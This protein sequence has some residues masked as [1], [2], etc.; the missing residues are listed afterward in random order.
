MSRDAEPARRR[1]LW[2]EL[3]GL[4]IGL[5]LLFAFKSDELPELPVLGAVTLL[6][7][8]YLWRDVGFDPQRFWSWRPHRAALRRVLLRFVLLAPLLVL[9]TVLLDPVRLWALPR[10][11]PGFWLFVVALYPFLS[12]YPQEVLYRGFFFHRYGELFA[13]RRLLLAANVLLFAFLHVIYHNGVAVLLTL[14]GGALFARTYERTGSIL[15]VSV[16]HT[17]YGIV[18]FT[19]GYDRYFL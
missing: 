4:F 17:L 3:L 8:A 15:V 14:V 2:G 7:T 11:R 19:A 18:L 12:A 10:E 6:V 16:E 9:G 5:P 13:D 1:Y